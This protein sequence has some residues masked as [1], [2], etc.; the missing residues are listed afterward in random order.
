[1][2]AIPYRFLSAGTGDPPA[3]RRSARGAPL[4]AAGV[5]GVALATAFSLAACG[6]PFT[7]RAAPTDSG[8]GGAPGQGGRAAAT[9][10]QAGGGGGGGDGGGG[11]GGGSD[12]TTVLVEDDTG[13]PVAGAH[14][15][16]NDEAGAVVQVTASDID[17]RVGV[18]IPPGGSA[19]VFSTGPY[20]L[21][22]HTL[23]D[24]PR[25]RTLPVTVQRPAGVLREATFYDVFPTDTPLNTAYMTLWASCEDWENFDLSYLNDACPDA[26]RQDLLVVAF[27]SQG[28][29]LA[30]GRAVDPRP[31]PGAY[32]MVSMAI[33]E[34]AFHTLATQM[35]GLVDAPDTQAITQVYGDF[36]NAALGEALAA[37][38]PQ[39]S[40]IRVPAIA[41][42]GYRI[43]DYV[44]SRSD[45]QGPRRILERRRHYAALPAA[46]TF[47]ADSMPLLEMN[48]PNLADPVH[49]ELS[50]SIA[51]GERGDQGGLALSWYSGGLSGDDLARIG[52][53]NH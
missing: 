18:T 25:G 15:V 42:M 27:D 44:S 47:A 24:P 14:V 37:P 36:Y 41:G 45:P 10:G 16:V 31:L 40:A 32:V 33:N 8:E 11:G 51:D 29:A 13:H 39:T 2:N 34:P 21:H 3:P 38:P 43:H 28:V 49:P 17:G 46:S 22:V 48:A 53:F 1:M 20:G 9:G 23:V 19:S 50:W 6:P 30:W 26:P 52:Q 7:L 35:T 12:E 5:L 4:R